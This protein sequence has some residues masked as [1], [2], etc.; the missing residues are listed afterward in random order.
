MSEN[1][2]KCD[3]NC[4]ETKN[5]KEFPDELKK[6][7]KDFITDVL[8]TFPEYKDKFTENELEYLKKDADIEKLKVVFNYFKTVFPERFFDILYENE[9]MFLDN[10]KNTKFFKNIDFK[11]IWKEKISE[12]TK[13][14]IWKYLQLTL[15]SLSK[16]IEGTDTFGDT[17]KMFEAIDE[18]VLKNKLEEVISSMND[19]FDMSNNKF[20]EMMNN[21]KENMQSNMDVSGMPNMDMFEE[22]MNNMK[23]NMQSNMDGMP[24]MGMFEEMMKNMKENMQSNMDGMP[25]MD[26]FEEMMNNMKE[27]MQSNMDVSGENKNIPNPEDIQNHLNSLMG[28][29]IGK[30]AQEIADETASELDIDT[31]NINGVGD[32]FSKLFKNPGQLMNMIKKVSSKLD[33]KLKSGEIK[34]SELMQEA[35]ELVEKM[36]NTPGMKDMEKM[37]GKMG[38]GGKGGK[39]NMNMFQ[40]MMK[41]NIKKSSQ[42]ERMLNKLKQRKQEREL[43]EKIK[44]SQQKKSQQNMQNYDEYI[45][46]T[47]NIDEKKIKKSKMKK[48][49]KNKK[50]GKK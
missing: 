23:E 38:M 1:T 21:M 25:N 20:E 39:V 50:K 5:L 45:Q 11:D 44:Q 22:M 33:Q 12:N 8:I 37:L 26:M 47:F 29:K 28:G 35:N 40:S 7:V 18:D 42:K 24:N 30:L 3:E 15:F 6:I 36:K 17:A 9:D 16:N 19:V 41:S 4:D 43:M 34:E 31:T 49:K 2:E 48:K 32:I 27:N 13:N 46:K 14:I 10:K